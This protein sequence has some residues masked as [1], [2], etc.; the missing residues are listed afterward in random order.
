MLTDYH[1]HIENGDYTLSWLQ[2]FIEKAK[3]QGIRELG[4]AEHAHRF[5]E[6]H[7]IHSHIWFDEWQTESI[8]KYLDL[9]QK[10]NAN[11]T[12][13][14]QGIEMDYL[15]DQE[16]EIK[17]FLDNY[18]FDY[19]IGSI[20]W[21]DKWGFDI[22]ALEYIWPKSDVKQVYLQYFETVIQMVE[23]KI[24]RAHV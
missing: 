24:G 6:A 19:I 2:K 22:P 13:I 10:A 14:K 12:R 5:K 20:H 23:S 7:H 9:L 1:V 8:E 3:S 16:N 15:P 17:I 18:D 21:L 11:G 4:I